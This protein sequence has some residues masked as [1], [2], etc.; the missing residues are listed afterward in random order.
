VAAPGTR[1][2]CRAEGPRYSPGCRR[3]SSHYPRRA[4]AQNLGDGPGGRQEIAFP[5]GMLRR[6]L[7]E[8]QAGRGR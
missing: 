4:P 2:G 6:F 7:T 1:P 3:A 8:D 5:A